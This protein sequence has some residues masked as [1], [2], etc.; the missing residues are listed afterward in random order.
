VPITPK[1]TGASGGRALR[2]LRRAAGLTQ[3][4]LAHAAR[5]SIAT[6]ALFEAGYAPERSTVLPRIIAVLNDER[7]RMTTAPNTRE[8]PS[9]REAAAGNHGFSKTAGVGDG[10]GKA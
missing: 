9:T 5:C 10:Y 2:D 3:V 1:A 4:E 8:A 6:V 7:G